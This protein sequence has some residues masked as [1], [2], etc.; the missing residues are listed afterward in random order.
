M[1]KMLLSSNPQRSS[2]RYKQNKKRSFDKYGRYEDEPVI[3]S[4]KV[5]SGETKGNPKPYKPPQDYEEMLRR[6]KRYKKE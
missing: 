6:Q 5:V 3:Y 2:R 4:W 1:A